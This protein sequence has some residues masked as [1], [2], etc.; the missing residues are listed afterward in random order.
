MFSFV[1][2][3]QLRDTDILRVNHNPASDITITHCQR[4]TGIR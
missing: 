1:L 4:R 3:L 2:D